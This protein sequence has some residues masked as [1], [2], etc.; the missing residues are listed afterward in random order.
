MKTLEDKHAVVTGAGS[1]IGRSIA[2]A[3]AEAGTH[4]VVADIDADTAAQ[5]AAEV[6]SRG[7][8]AQAVTC[9]VSNVEDV[10]RLADA[11]YAAFGR[12][13]VLCNNAGAT[14]RP[15]RN[16]MDTTLEEWRFLFGINLWGVLH[17]LHVFLP[18][19]RRQDGEKHVVNTSSLAALLPMEG[20]A[21]YSASKGAV[22][23]LTEA[24]TGELAPYG[25]GVT[26]LCPG[27]VDTNLGANAAKIWKAAVPPEARTF[28]PVDTVMMDRVG[29]LARP[30]VAQVGQMVVDAILNDIPH[31]HT[32]RLDAPLL[33]ER[34]KLLFGDQTL[35]R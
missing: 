31:I 5:V 10:G 20:H 6:A 8:R 23:A 17:G 18:R 12:V 29:R 25:F 34:M 26:N 28:D 1:G 4:V 11:A 16:I 27:P 30:H 32:T 24:I 9:D 15:Y 3:L 21:A 35:R 13:D 22:M 2:L 19:M 14:M 33:A 7:V